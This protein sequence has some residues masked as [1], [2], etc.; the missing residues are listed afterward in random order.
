MLIWRPN[1]KEEVTSVCL[2]EGMYS[3]GSHQGNKQAGRMNG[4]TQMYELL[5]SDPTETTLL[6]VDR[7]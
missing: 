5:K 6:Y 1:H 4:G 2:G 7:K 3:Q